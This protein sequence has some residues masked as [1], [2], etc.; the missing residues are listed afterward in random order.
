[1][2]GFCPPGNKIP[3]KFTPSAH[4]L[5]NPGGH[6]ACSDKEK[7]CSYCI[8]NSISDPQVALKDG[9]QSLYA[10]GVERANHLETNYEC[11][12]KVNLVTLKARKWES[13]FQWPLGLGLK[14]SNKAST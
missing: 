12:T 4:V 9:H 14:I 5:K 13:L 7:V 3:Q 10:I 1:M 8:R 11:I 2:S 6:H